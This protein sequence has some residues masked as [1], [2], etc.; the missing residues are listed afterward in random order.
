M[1]DS[2]TYMTDSQTDLPETEATATEVLT[3]LVTEAIATEATEVVSPPSR[4][5]HVRIAA[6]EGTFLIM[7]GEIKNESNCTLC[8]SMYPTGEPPKTLPGQTVLRMESSEL[9][10]LLSKN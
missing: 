6:A 5:N 3:P 10:F 1:A 8:L 7:E 4:W 9:Y 2:Q